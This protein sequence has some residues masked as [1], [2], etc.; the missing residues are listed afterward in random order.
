MRCSPLL[1]VM[2]GVGKTMAVVRALAL[3]ILIVL[4]VSGRGVTPGGE[5]GPH[6]AECSS[7]TDAAKHAI[8]KVERTARAPA[9]VHRFKPPLAPLLEATAASDRSGVLVGMQSNFDPVAHRP[10]TRKSLYRPRAR[11]ALEPALR[12]A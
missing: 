2:L 10:P 7:P 3:A 6:N 4:V 9:T 8:V 11:S 1:D 5:R 12:V